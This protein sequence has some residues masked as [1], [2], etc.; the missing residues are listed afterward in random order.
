ME[1]FKGRR[2]AIYARV[3]TEEQA[4]HGYSIEGQKEMLR[5]YCQLYNKVV[6]D[7]YV[8][9]GISGKEMSKRIELQRLLKDAEENKFDE[10]LVWKFSRMSRNTK[11]LLEIVD[12]LEKNGVHF[13]SISEK[14]DT[15][16]PMGRFA[17]QM[18]AAIGELERNTIV[19]NV[20]M[21]LKQ[22]AKQGLHSGGR[23][24]GYK[25]VI[26]QNANRSGKKEFVIIPE[27][28]DIVRKIFSLFASGKGLKA[29][30]NKLN[31]EGYK[32][33]KGNVFSTC[34]IRE[35]LDNPIYKGYVRYARYENWSEKRRKGKNPNPIIIK[36][37]F[38]AII[39]EELWDQVAKLRALKNKDTARA[40]D[41]HNILSS[42]LRCPECGAPMVVSRSRTKIKDGGIKVYRYY[43]CSKFKNYGSSVCHANS[44]K[45]DEAEE[46]VI[47]MIKRVLKHPRILC[48]ILN[49]LKKKS[50]EKPDNLEGEIK[51]LDKQ[52]SEINKRR[53]RLADLY[54]YGQ[55]DKEMLDSRINDIA[56][57]FMQLQELRQSLSVQNEVAMVK[58]NDASIKNLLSHFELVM[59]SS[60][61]DRKYLL[62]RLLI[63]KITVKDRKIEQIYFRLGKELQDYM[64]SNNLSTDKVEGLFLCPNKVLEKLVFKI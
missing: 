11:D 25:A 55:I 51:R 17:F 47:K 29:I 4:E 48:D 2:V 1:E 35:I 61:I 46:Y 50:Q 15:S 7:E 38:E 18:M 56:K 22:R 6:V 39:S 43:S 3:S 20:R 63:E 24:L 62:M 34:A 59:G 27:E 53:E 49:R 32:T 30:A 16:S 13:S 40:Y 54:A 42:I 26:S 9:A 44:I 31:H 60:D 5:Q 14:F 28:A 23:A 57:E 58:I 52:I 37:Q 19:E 41:S 8:D 21:G 64:Q 45:A 10:V 36:G 12:K 33:V